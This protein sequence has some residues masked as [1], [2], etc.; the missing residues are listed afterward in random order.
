MQAEFLG[1]KNLGK[2]LKSKSSTSRNVE[3]N[4]H[5]DIDIDVEGN[6]GI[7]N[8]Q[9]VCSSTMPNSKGKTRAISPEV[10]INM[11]D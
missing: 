10:N 11:Q 6:G 2:R 7:K 9:Q 1:K 5:M 8:S 3:V 4:N